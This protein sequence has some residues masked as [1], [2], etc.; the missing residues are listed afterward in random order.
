MELPILT[1]QSEETPGEEEVEDDR[2]ERESLVH[3]A[4]ETESGEMDVAR[5]TACRSPRRLMW[6]DLC[7]ECEYAT[8]PI[9]LSGFLRD[10]AKKPG[11]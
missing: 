6:A 7:W 4:A 9:D 3:Q 8:A 2:L 11:D 1:G 5:C 10:L